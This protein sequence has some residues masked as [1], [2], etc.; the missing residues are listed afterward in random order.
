MPQRPRTALLR[1]HGQFCRVTVVS[2]RGAGR[3]RPAPG[4]VLGLRLSD[5]LRAI[6]GEGS[7]T[8]AEGWVTRF[9][10][11]RPVLCSFAAAD[12]A[13]PAGM[14]AGSVKFI[15]RDCFP[16]VA[17]ELILSC[18]CPSMANKANKIRPRR[19]QQSPLILPHETAENRQYAEH[20]VPPHAL[21]WTLPRRCS[22]F[23]RHSSHSFKCF[24]KYSN[25]LAGIFSSTSA[26][27]S[28]Q[29]GRL[30][31]LAHVHRSWQ[32]A[33]PHVG[34]GSSLTVRTGAGS[35]SCT[36]ERIFRGKRE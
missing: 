19:D 35:S 12:A 36:S 13:R 32:F 23:S 34:R 24:R 21:P 26:K 33:P 15:C 8:C 7:R 28:S 14:G 31:V 11:Y 9:S 3:A 20:H 4:E 16:A 30:P 22:T 17:N 2:G 27:T 25:R 6:I 18:R 29:I 10:S 1:I 5:T